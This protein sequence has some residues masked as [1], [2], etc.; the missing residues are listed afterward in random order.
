MIQYYRFGSKAATI[1]TKFQ[2]QKQNFARNNVFNLIFNI[3]L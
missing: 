2:G 3:K 1:G